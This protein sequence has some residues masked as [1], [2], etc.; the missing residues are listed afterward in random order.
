M[1]MRV[2]RLVIIV[3]DGRTRTEAA[4]AGRYSW[5][6]LSNCDPA[7]GPGS[8]YPSCP[9]GGFVEN[10]MLRVPGSESNQVIVITIL[11]PGHGSSWQ[12]SATRPKSPAPTPAGGEGITALGAM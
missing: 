10:A 3:N 1:D 8:S 11:H 6:N 12:L 5:S 2:R 4:F 9:A 7:S